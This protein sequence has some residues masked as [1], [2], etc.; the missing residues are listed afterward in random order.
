MLGAS[1]L[2][3]NGVL[4]RNPA[5]VH[6]APPSLERNRSSW[7]PSCCVAVNAYT[8]ASPGEPTPRVI[9]PALIVPVGAGKVSVNAAKACHVAPWSVEAASLPTPSVAAVAATPT[10]G[11]SVETTQPLLVFTMLH[12]DCRKAPTGVTYMSGRL[13]FR[14]NVAPPLAERNRPI[15]VA[16]STTSTGPLVSTFRS[17]T[18]PADVL[19]NRR[20]TAGPQVFPP[21]VLF[22]TYAPAAAL[23]SNGSPRPR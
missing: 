7:A 21:S 11:A 3:F 8:L 15:S 16:T 17:R 23:P 19:P 9:R 10:V 14:V 6:V 5:G 1:G 2:G 18:L 20:R 22:S 13:R 12:S 4:L